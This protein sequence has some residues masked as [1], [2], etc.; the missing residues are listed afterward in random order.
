MSNIKEVA[1][2]ADVS[3]ST[4]SRTINNS[5]LISEETKERVMKEIKRLNYS[6]NLI[7]KSLS[8]SNSYTVTLLVDVDDE[9]SFQNPFFYEIM[10][11]IEKFVYQNEYSLIV[12][13]LK[14]KM[15]KHSVLNWLV[16]AKRTEGVI[17]PSSILDSDMINEF[18]NDGIPFVAIG[19]PTQLKDPICWV[20]VDNK[21]GGELG[22]YSL[23]DKGYKNIAFIGYDKGKVF[24]QRRFEGYSSA[25][26]KSK[27]KFQDRY[28]IEC[29]NTK[30]D[31]YLSM[32]ELLTECPEIDAVLCADNLLSYGVIKAINEAGKSIP[33]EIGL[34]SF[35]NRQIAELSYP[36]I[37]TVNVDVFELGIQSAKLL[38]ELIKN[39]Q[40]KNQGL[41]ISTNIDERETT[42]TE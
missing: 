35:D 34:I 4:V 31:G 2:A 24:S 33:N 5:P 27:M 9:K 21:K 1:K 38:F 20:D 17:L 8:T 32:K 22:T 23:I 26:S 30:N 40:A 25:L 14:T 42:K 19:E 11:G 18:K 28:V 37:S 10:H 16:K 15:K 41:L 39:P 12:A 3:V 6:P 29:D 7:A 36:T 13:N